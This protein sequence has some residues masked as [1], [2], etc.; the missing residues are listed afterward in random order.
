M[1]RDQFLSKIRTNLPQAL[2]PQASPEHPGAFPA[3]APVG[4]TRPELIEQ[5][6][7]ELEALSGYVH[8]PEDRPAALQTV[9]DLI[10]SHHAERI[11]AWDEASLGLP[12][13]TASLA[14]AGIIIED[15]YVPAT[16]ET[17]RARLD[18]LD[19]VLVGLTGADGGLADTGAI[20]LSSGPGRGRLAS[21]LPPVHLALLPATK[22]YPSLPAFLSAPPPATDAG[23]DASSNLV[24]ITGPSRTGDIE[25][26]LSMGVHG[27]GEV[28]VIIIPTAASS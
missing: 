26:T 3:P 4:A 8:L 22:L 13:L 23:G 1:E 10:R 9:L 17:R 11:L 28:H 14:E 12:G 25:M 27:P 18:R 6:K 15:S 24:F 20:A 2:L 5:F 16:G 7:R 21:L 19:G